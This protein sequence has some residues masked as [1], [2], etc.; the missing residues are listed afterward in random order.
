M[1]IKYIKLLSEDHRI[2]H[3]LSFF[4]DYELTF[5]DGEKKSIYKDAL[6]QKRCFSNLD[7]VFDLI[8]TTFFHTQ[9][10]PGGDGIDTEKSIH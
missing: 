9:Q 3:F 6:S 4:W 1:D 8:K 7:D 10:V 2:K 5:P